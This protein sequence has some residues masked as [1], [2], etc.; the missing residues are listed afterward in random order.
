[1]TGDDH[2]NNNRLAQKLRELRKAHSYTQYD[3]ASMLGVVRQ[4]YSHYETGKRS[5]DSEALYK[6]AGFYHIS[7]EDL[8]H[9]TIELDK[10]DYFDAPLATKSSY[11]L[12]DYL[13]YI[14]SPAN[15]RKLKNL[16][17]FEKEALF[18]FSR[19]SMEDKR[20]ILEFLKIKA[21][22]KRL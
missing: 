10:N 8:M 14:N 15:Q 22:K 6:L 20:E 12:D 4:T 9:L 1:M 3:V 11:S 13:T 2:V 21:Q 16:T 18:Y 5:P 17:D 7:V 19:I